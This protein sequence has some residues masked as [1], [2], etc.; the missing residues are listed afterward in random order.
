MKE[1]QIF[2]EVT[3]TR[4]LVLGGVKI[5]GLTQ[6]KINTSQPHSLRKQLEYDF[7]HTQ[8]LLYG[9]LFFYGKFACP[10]GKK[11]LTLSLIIQPA[12][13]KHHINTDTFRV[14]TYQK[15]KNS[16]TFS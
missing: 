1:G 7:C 10:W 16:L 14:V 12:Q 5:C 9:N 11:A 15:V 6:L 13:Y 3:C 2:S 4:Y 8:T